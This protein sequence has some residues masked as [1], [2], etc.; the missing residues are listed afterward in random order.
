MAEE[1]L[2]ASTRIP[3]LCGRASLRHRSG[4]RQRIRPPGIPGL[5]VRA[6]LRHQPHRRRPRRH[7]CIPGL[8][9]RAPLRHDRDLADSDRYRPY[10]RP[11]QPGS[12]EAPLT[13]PS[14]RSTSAGIPGRTA[15]Q[16]TAHSKIPKVEAP[17]RHGPR[18]KPRKSG[19]RSRNETKLA[20]G[21]ADYSCTPLL[22]INRT[23][24]PACASVP[25]TS[26]SKMLP[27]HATSAWDQQAELVALTVTH[28]VPTGGST[29]C[30]TVDQA[31]RKR[32]AASRSG[33]SS[34]TRGPY[35]RSR[36]SSIGI[37]HE[38]SPSHAVAKLLT[39]PKPAG[40]QALSSARTRGPQS[41]N[42]PP[43][44]FSRRCAERHTHKCGHPQPHQQ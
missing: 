44:Q 43:G 4:H 14:A 15:H 10:S 21:E 12:I 1:Q 30:L 32:A 13:R 38:K 2:R 11:L 39:E 37:E 40:I 8:C 29:Q 20:P 33:P 5:C 19:Q 18:G 41:F 36:E 7:V 17:H 23:A 16:D 24:D 42:Q 27:S 26:L 31:H 3:G 34:M 22:T 9:G 28:H 6:P 35:T 25:Q